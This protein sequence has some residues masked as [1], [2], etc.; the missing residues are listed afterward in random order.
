M[1]DTEDVQIFCF[2]RKLKIVSVIATSCFFVLVAMS[3]YAGIFDTSIKTTGERLLLLS[4][5]LFFLML[6][7]RLAWVRE[8]LAG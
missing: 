5:S 7:H 6:G 4:I 8:L 3:F 2:S 1:S